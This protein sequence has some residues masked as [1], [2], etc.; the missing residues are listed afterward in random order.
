LTKPKN[1]SV[2]ELKHK[3]ASAKAFTPYV[4]S[5]AQNPNLHDSLEFV[6]EKYRQGSEYRGQKWR[7]MRHGH[8]VFLYLDGGKYEGDWSFSKM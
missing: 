2:R 1:D 3:Q 8:G 4:P 7:G 5:Q 6:V